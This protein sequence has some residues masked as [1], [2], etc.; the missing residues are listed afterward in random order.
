MLTRNHWDLLA[1]LV[2]YVAEKTAHPRFT[3][4]R[5]SMKLQ[6][7]QSPSTPLISFAEKSGSLVIGAFSGNRVSIN[8]CSRS[9]P[10]GY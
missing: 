9:P 7:S 2:E 5:L 3:S 4:V 8:S 1:D 10:E 6:I